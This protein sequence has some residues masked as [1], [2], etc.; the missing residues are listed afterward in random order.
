MKKANT[1]TP[2]VWYLHNLFN[3]YANRKRNQRKKCRLIYDLRSNLFFLLSSRRRIVNS[4]Q[5]KYVI[6]FNVIFSLG[7]SFASKG[8]N[9]FDPR[10]KMH[11]GI[12]C[13]FYGMNKA[14]IR[15]IM[16]I[17]IGSFPPIRRTLNS[18]SLTIQMIIFN[19]WR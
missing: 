2:F 19:G 9:T 3:F 5:L 16:I 12:K 7:I 15:K 14:V 6:R 17:K 13:I 1:T 4:G 18:N 8:N 11:G 10:S